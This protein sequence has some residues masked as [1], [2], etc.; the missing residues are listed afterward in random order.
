MARWE[1]RNGRC[2]AE[3]PFPALTKH[4][5]STEG[6][7]DEVP[8]FSYLEKGGSNTRLSWMLKDRSYE[9]CLL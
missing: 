3:T 8:L 1:L 4:V 7:E 2:V 9:E 5:S 6:S